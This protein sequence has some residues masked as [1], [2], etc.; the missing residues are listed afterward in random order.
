MEYIGND[1]FSTYK[2]LRHIALAEGSKLEEI[3]SD[4]FSES[5]L[6]EVML[7]K[8][9]KEIGYG[10]FDECKHLK[11]IRV[12]EGCE[13]SLLHVREPESVIIGPPPETMTGSM[14]VWD[15]RNVKYVVFPEGV[16]K[17]GNYWFWGSEVM[18]IKIPASV[19]EIG[20]GAFGMCKELWHVVFAP[21]SALE[22]TG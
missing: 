19:R 5:G 9:L 3:G 10:A 13:A 14:R 8:T 11:S 2:A 17:I 6:E 7:P 22:R 20:A 1:A 4:C 21:G 12:E 15:L 18:S 16:E